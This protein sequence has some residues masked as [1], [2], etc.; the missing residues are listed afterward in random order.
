MDEVMDKRFA[1][2]PKM[3][4]V[5]S[6]QAA[7]GI[8]NILAGSFYTEHLFLAIYSLVVKNDYEKARQHFHTCAMLDILRMGKFNSR[9]LDYGIPNIC[10]A[11]LRDNS[12]LIAKYANQFTKEMEKL[13]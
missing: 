11:V 4:Q 2:H 1:V 12:I 7:E 8:D 9:I 13:S 10:N 5:L 6:K 3:M